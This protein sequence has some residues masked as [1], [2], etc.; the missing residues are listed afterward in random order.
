MDDLE[1]KIRENVHAHQIQDFSKP[2][3]QTTIIEE[4]VQKNMEF[5]NKRKH[6]QQQQIQ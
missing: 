6:Q 1:Q 2:V 4:D 5:N 3:I